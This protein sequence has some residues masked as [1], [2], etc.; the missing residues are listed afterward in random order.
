MAISLKKSKFW[1]KKAFCLLTINFEH[2]VHFPPGFDTDIYVR[3]CECLRLYYIPYKNQLYYK[4]YSLM[5]NVMP[6]LP[7]EL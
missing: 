7:C 1:F 4:L 2:I 6:K 5:H 3:V